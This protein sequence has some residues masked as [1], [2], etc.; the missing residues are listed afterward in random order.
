M[1]PTIFDLQK[2]SGNLQTWGGMI[3]VVIN[4]KHS[5]MR[6]IRAFRRG[7][8]E[9]ANEFTGQIPTR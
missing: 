9:G 4:G 6:R 8:C 1:K 3:R 2:L 7:L 5:Q